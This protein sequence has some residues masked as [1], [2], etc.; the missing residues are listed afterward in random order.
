MKPPTL[1]E[2]AIEGKYMKWH[3]LREKPKDFAD[4][5]IRWVILQYLKK[6]DGGNPQP[7][8]MAYWDTHFRCWID[9]E[10]VDPV[11]TYRVRLI[12]WAHLPKPKHLGRT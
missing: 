7:F 2:R 1:E 12:C 3:S 11:E 4:G 8:T 5:T 10:G 9:S 6:A